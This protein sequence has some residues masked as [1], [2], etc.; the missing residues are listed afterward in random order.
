MP[1]VN[2]DQGKKQFYTS[3]Y[4]LAKM[5]AW[6]KTWKK[7][8]QLYFTENINAAKINKGGIF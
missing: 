8:I 3:H 6:N 7:Y 4:Y 2:D 5:T 1:T